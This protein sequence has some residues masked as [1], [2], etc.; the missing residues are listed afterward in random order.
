MGAIYPWGNDWREDH[1]NTEEA[2]IN[3]RV[4]W[5]VFHKGRVHM[6]VWTWRAMYGSGRGVS[7]ARIWRSR[8]LLSL[9]PEDGREDLAASDNVARVLRGGSYFPNQRDA[10]CACRDWRYPNH[11]FDVDLG[12][13]VVVL[14]KL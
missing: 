14:P 9:Q 3:S 1:A 13:R 8:L 2:G 10:R 12:F 5:G 11:V 7:G 4:R 6:D